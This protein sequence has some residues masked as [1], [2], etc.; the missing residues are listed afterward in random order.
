MIVTFGK[1]LPLDERLQIDHIR[2]AAMRN[3]RCRYG[4]RH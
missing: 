2:R 3:L 4:Y 1:H